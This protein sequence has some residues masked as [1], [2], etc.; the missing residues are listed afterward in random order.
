VSEPHDKAP[1]A[2]AVIPSERAM[3]PLVATGLRILERAPDPATLREL[4]AVQREWEAGEARKAFAAD[5]VALKRDLPRVIDRDAVVDFT[6][7]AGKRTFYRHMSLANMMD[8]IAEPVT[9]HGF[10]LSFHPATSKDGVSVTCRL[11]HREGHFDEVTIGPVPSDTSGN[12]SPAQAV[13]STITLLSRYAATALLGIA[14]ADM[15]EPHSEEPPPSPDKV[16]SARNLRAVGLLKKHGRTVEAAV[17]F[18]DGRAV[19]DWTENDLKKL[20]A[21]AKSPAPT[22][23][24]PQ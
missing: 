5:H 24:T 17:S 15:H 19:E 14:T 18:L 2:L 23:G 16:D 20:E 22:K 13:A 6:N 4:L 11:M 1:A 21:W 3:S 9:Q 7:N 8:K 10:A 12:K